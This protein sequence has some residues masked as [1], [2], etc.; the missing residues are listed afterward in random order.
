[1]MGHRTWI[2]KGPQQPADQQQ[3]DVS[4]VELI[5]DRLFPITAGLNLAIVPGL[6][7]TLALQNFQMDG[8]LIAHLPVFLSVRKENLGHV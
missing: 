3:D 8:Q 1:M 5:V 4:P 2:E 7:F 6:D